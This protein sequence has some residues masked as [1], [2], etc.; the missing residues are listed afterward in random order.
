MKALALWF[1]LSGTPIAALAGISDSQR[2]FLMIR[3]LGGAIDLAAS[4]SSCSGVI[5]REEFNRVF[6]RASPGRFVD[7]MNRAARE[8]LRVNRGSDEAWQ[9]ASQKLLVG[10][11]SRL[12]LDRALE[13]D[14]CLASAK[15]VSHLQELRNS[16]DFIRS[17]KRSTLAKFA[18]HYSLYSKF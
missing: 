7:L 11:S 2:D 5:S 10:L 17:V 9:A 15:M 14:F 18:W 4:R 12:N 16:E 8:E 13:R 1:F 3:V 6:G